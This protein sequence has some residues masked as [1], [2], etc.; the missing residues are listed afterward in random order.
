L[1]ERDGTVA[2]K[3][4]NVHPVRIQDRARMRRARYAGVGSVAHHASHVLEG[5]K[6]VSA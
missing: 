3:W 6:R 1:L 2:K 4:K 5:R